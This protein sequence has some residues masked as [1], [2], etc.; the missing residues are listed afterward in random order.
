MKYKLIVLDVDGTM[1]N[2]N[3]E[4]T[5]RTVQTLR[6]VQQMGIKVALA[7]GRPTYGILPLA[8]QIDLDVYEGY[9]IS[10]NGAQVMEA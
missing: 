10:Y 8:R 2:S 3:R 9:I 4:V 6:R 7:S 5:K 1:L